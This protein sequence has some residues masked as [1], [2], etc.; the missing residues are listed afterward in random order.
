MLYVLAI[1]LLPSD[2]T[3]FVMS[4]SFCMICLY[5]Y[6]PDQPR[7]KLMSRIIM[8]GHLCSL[9]V[10]SQEKICEEKGAEKDQIAADLAKAKSQLL[11]S[12][13]SMQSLQ[14]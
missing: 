4:V 1:I 10:S 5:L 7:D 3:M 14:V 12:T 6:I 11:E 8:N 9:K 13:N 2:A